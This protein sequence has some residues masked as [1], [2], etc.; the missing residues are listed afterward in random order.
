[1]KNNKLYVQI[2]SKKLGILLMD[3]RLSKKSSV[4][5]ISKNTGIAEDR[6]I[7]F[8]NGSLSPSLPELEISINIKDQKQNHWCEY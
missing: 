2:R 1:M 6:L 3:A 4:D 8:E 7:Q 5:E